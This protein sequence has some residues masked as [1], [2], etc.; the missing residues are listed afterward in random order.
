MNRLP[1]FKFD[2]RLWLTGS[3]QVCSHEEKGTFINLC[4]L[5]WNEQTG[6]IK[7]SDL[8]HRRLRMDKGTFNDTLSNL[9]EFGLIQE[10]DGILSVKF[11]TE[12]INDYNSFV[13]K[14]SESGKKGGRPKRVPKAKKKEERRKNKEIEDIPPIPPFDYSEFNQP[15]QDAISEWLEYKPKNHYKEKGF[16]AF[17]TILTKAIAQHGEVVVIDRITQ[18]MA[19]SWV[20]LNLDK[21]ET[22]KKSNDPVPTK[23]AVKFSQEQWDALDDTDR[24]MVCAMADNN[25]RP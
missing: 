4:A 18:A 10:K 16:K 25:W 24:K 22:P 21:I 19:N 17:K 1:Y 7:N 12:Q 15:I 20:G 9:I 5:I 23:V 6:C 11:L 2:V 8:L 14:C 3:I 13:K